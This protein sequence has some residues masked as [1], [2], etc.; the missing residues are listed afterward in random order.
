MF[1]FLSIFADI[2]ATNRLVF[3]KMN[4][5]RHLFKSGFQWI[6][7]LKFIRVNKIITFI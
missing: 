4:H 2:L 1:Q 3:S 6:N 5:Q 7:Y